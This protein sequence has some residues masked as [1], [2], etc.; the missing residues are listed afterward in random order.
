VKNIIE[1]GK[2]FKIIPSNYQSATLL[3][4]KK[5][6]DDSFEAELSYISENEL[7]DY[8]QKGEVEVF[9]SSE[10][11]LVYFTTEIL[12]KNGKIL[13]IK[14]PQKHKSIQRREYSR[15]DFNGKVKLNDFKD[16][17][18][19]SKDISA[20]GI[21]I[22]VD[23]PLEIGK[24]YAS[25]IVLTN[26]MTI[27]TTIQPIRVSEV[28]VKPSPKKELYMVSGR[29]KNIESIDRIAL[30]QYSFKALMEAENKK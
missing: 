19:I 26:N 3:E 12:E 8:E 10:E 15:V 5:V 6:K 14:I 1:N 23:K 21:R 16:I 29:F 20:G 7:N 4:V 25:T 11:G 13:T 18:V 27:N 2:D 24:E 9:G 30:V 22:L 17:E 28:D